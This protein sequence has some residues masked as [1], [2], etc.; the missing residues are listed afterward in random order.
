M[1][2]CLFNLRGLRGF[3]K[4][5]I[6]SYLSKVNYLKYIRIDIKCKSNNS[7]RLLGPVCPAGVR[8]E[9]STRLGKS[10]ARLAGS[11]TGFCS[12]L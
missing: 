4:N 12:L 9:R 3:N 10:Q 5:R 2:E 1:L 8:R 7:G 6:R 11:P